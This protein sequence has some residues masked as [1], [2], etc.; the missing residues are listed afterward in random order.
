MVVECC[1]LGAELENPVEAVSMSLREV[2]LWRTGLTAWYIDLDYLLDSDIDL[3][4]VTLRI[5]PCVTI[6]TGQRLRCVYTCTYP[7]YNIYILLSRLF[8][9]CVF[10]SLWEALL[11]FTTWGNP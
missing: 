7:V 1:R 10:T 9:A 4:S 3:S 11:V 2:E 6:G 5:L 8:A